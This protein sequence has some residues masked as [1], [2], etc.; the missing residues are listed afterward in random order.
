MYIKMPFSDD[1]Q[2]TYAIR[3]RH[4][5][6]VLHISKPWKWKKKNEKKGVGCKKGGMLCPVHKYL[7]YITHAMYKCTSHIKKNEHAKTKQ[8]TNNNK[9]KQANKKIIHTYVVYAL[10]LYSVVTYMYS[11]LHFWTV[12]IFTIKT[13]SDRITYIIFNLLKASISIW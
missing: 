3:K 9:Q 11:T 12:G 6:A 4:I 8:K 2:S 7:C 1:T 5:M 13:N 10:K